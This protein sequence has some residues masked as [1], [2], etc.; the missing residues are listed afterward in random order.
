MVVMGR[1]GCLGEDGGNNRAFLDP[2][3]GLEA[4]AA[5]AVAAAAGCDG[6]NAGAS[7]VD[8]EDPPCVKG[9]A[10]PAA[11]ELADEMYDMGD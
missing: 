6:L 10:M 5:A 8:W 11:V 1:G 2:T 4:T 3:S 7:S 9:L